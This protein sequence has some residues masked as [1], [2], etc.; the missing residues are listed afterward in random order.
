MDAAATK[1]KTKLSE[2][3]KQPV[4]TFTSAEMALELIRGVVKVE[5]HT[6]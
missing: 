2:D 3:F 5:F 6:P 1:I 4:A